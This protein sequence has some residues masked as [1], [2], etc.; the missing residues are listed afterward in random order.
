MRMPG[1]SESKVARAAQN[2]QVVALVLCITYLVYSK[3]E[4]SFSM[5]H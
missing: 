4:S 1:K 2:S 5:I 3:L